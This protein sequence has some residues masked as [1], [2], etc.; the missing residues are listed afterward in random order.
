MTHPNEPEF[1]EPR[2]QVSPQMDPAYW[3]A[4]DIEPLPP[5]P[6]KRERLFPRK[7]LIGWA[8]ATAAVYFGV[9]VAKIA[10]KEAVRHAA[11]Y[12]TGLE[13]STDHRQVIYTTPNG[14]MIIVKDRETGQITIRKSKNGEVIRQPARPTPPE[15]PTRVT[16]DGPPDP[17]EVPA[18]AAKR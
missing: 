17:L 9:Q 11:V 7:V 1:A 4:A 10:I 8:L 3:S 15:R 5:P 2:T 13:T 18:P 6:F 12:T 14:R 16:T